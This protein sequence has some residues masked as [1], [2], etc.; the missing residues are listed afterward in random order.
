MAPGGEA[1]QPHPLPSLS[2]QVLSLLRHSL[3]TATATCL[4]G[5]PPP[6]PPT[7]VCPPSGLCP[8]TWNPLQ[9]AGVLLSSVDLVCYR[10]QG[11]LFG[12]LWVTSHRVLDTMSPSLL[13]IIPSLDAALGT[14]NFRLPLLPNSPSPFKTCSNV[15]PSR[16]MSPSPS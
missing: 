14:Q 12:L 9:A 11:Q 4:P 7:A 2:W 13:K 5:V 15:L 16:K 10:M 3:Q 6:P 8:S 1:E